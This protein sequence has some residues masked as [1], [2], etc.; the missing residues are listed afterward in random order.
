MY[1]CGFFL[2]SIVAFLLSCFFYDGPTL[3]IDREW[4]RGDLS[5][6]EIREMVMRVFPKLLKPSTICAWASWFSLQGW[7]QCPSLVTKWKGH[8]C[9]EVWSLEVLPQSKN[10]TLQK[11]RSLFCRLRGNLCFPYLVE[12]ALTGKESFHGASWGWQDSFEICRLWAQGYKNGRL[13][14]KGKT[15]KA[16]WCPSPSSA[17]SSL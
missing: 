6:L 13:P 1:F 14:W 2:N 7:G 17:Q 3:C 10:Q 8:S 9:P 4:A 15:P 11:Q 5:S 16:L 12:I